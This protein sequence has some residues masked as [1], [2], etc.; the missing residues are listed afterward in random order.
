MLMLDIF[1]FRALWSPYLFLF[2]VFVLALFFLITVFYQHHFSSSVPLTK[3]QGFFFTIGILLLYI[4]KGSPVDLLG[5]ITF[6]THMIQM[7]FLYLVIP[8]L[9]LIGIPPW[10]WRAIVNSRRIKPFFRFF[11]MPLISLLL[12]NGFFSIYHIPLVFDA[13][14]T[15]IFYHAGYTGLLFILAIFMWWPLLNQ[16]PE[17]QKLAGLKKIG[18]IFADGAL[19]TPACALIIFASDPVYATYSD[20]GAWA[21]ALELCVPQT[22]LSGLSLSG[23]EMFS[24]ISLLH[25][26]Q[27]GGVLM[28]VIQEIVYGTVLFHVFFTW[29]REEQQEVKIIE[30]DTP[31]Y[32]QAVEQVKASSN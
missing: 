14:K 16:L 29:Y 15:N 13:V 22:T 20:P 21:K 23:P 19:L 8:P 5:H 3:K 26:Q 18:Y 12:F 7:A 1:G 11:T 4:I 28:K 32:P 2:L 25:D 24:S 10:I 9:L 31:L 30:E 6:Y 17:H 27:L